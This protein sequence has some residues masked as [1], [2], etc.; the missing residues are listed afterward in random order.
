MLYIKIWRQLSIQIFQQSLDYFGFSSQSLNTDHL[1]EFHPNHRVYLFQPKMGLRHCSCSHHER[2]DD[3][4][5]ASISILFPCAISQPIY[6]DLPLPPFGIPSRAPHLWT[7]PRITHLPYQPKA[8]YRTV[9][10]R[11]AYPP[12]HS[13]AMPMPIKKFSRGPQFL[14]RKPFLALCVSRDVGREEPGLPSA[15]LVRSD[16]TR[17]DWDS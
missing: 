10:H 11:K 16:D 9:P 8:R 4:K 3:I 5:H 7:V 6:P 12:P 1:S 14:R 17:R 2:E 15:P 13:H